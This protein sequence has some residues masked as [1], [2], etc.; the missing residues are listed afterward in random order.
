MLMRA[1]AFR[2][3]RGP[4]SGLTHP[5]KERG[6]QQASARTRRGHGPGAPCGLLAAQEAA[7]RVNKPPGSPWSGRGWGPRETR[8]V[9]RVGATVHAGLLSSAAAPGLAA[10]LSGPR[11]SLARATCQHLWGRARPAARSGHFPSGSFRRPEK[12]RPRVNRETVRAHPPPSAQPSHAK[13]QAAS[14]L[15]SQGSHNFP[16]DSVFSAVKWGGT[17]TFLRAGPWNPGLVQEGVLE[18]G[19]CGADT[20]ARSG[21]P[22]PTGDGP[23]Q[24]G[25]S[26]RSP[27]LSQSA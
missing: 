4:V 9:T 8:W 22:A 14:P 18:E 3:G 19:V 13:P 7:L 20:R 26:E 11:D 27:V 1:T 6:S 16:P 15:E 10:G 12:P 2:K 24:E 25:T 23:E 17:I 21:V 5:E